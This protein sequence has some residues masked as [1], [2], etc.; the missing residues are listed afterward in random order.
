MF[1]DLALADLS[2]AADL[3]QR[4]FAR[5]D[6]VDGCVSLEV[7]PLLAHD[8]NATLAAARDLHRRAGVQL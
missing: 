8:T 6:G 4:V 5:A 1:F 2:R 3:F 7:S